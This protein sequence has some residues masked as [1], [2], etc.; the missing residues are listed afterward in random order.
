VVDYR[1]LGPIEADVNGVALDIGGQKQRALLAV[2]VLGANE[3]VPRDVLV[4]RLWGNIPRPALSTRL[5]CTSHACGRRWSRPPAGR[6][7]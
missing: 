5:R 6:S 1:L 3:P 4:D 2:L 7:C